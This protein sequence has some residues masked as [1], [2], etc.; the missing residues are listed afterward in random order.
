M[1]QIKSKILTLR[2]FLPLREKI[3]AEGGKVVFTNGCFDIIHR[4]HV[5]YLEKARS[6]GDCLV[7]GMNSDRSVG[8]IKGSERPIVLQDDRAIVLSAL[9]MVDYVIIFDEPTPADLIEAIHPD[10]LAKGADWSEEQI[11]GADAVKAGG[12]EVVRIELTDGRSTSSIIDK[13]L[14]K[15]K[16]AKN[17]TA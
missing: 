7:V 1:R 16:G 15:T 12:G 6:Y 14:S 10:I 11:V 9:Q 5:E 2:D 13:I 4:G 8:E 3:R 17:G